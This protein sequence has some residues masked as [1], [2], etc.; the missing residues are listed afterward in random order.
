MDLATVVLTSALFHEQP[1][2]GRW[3]VPLMASLLVVGAVVVVVSRRRGTGM[4]RSGLRY[5]P[6]MVVVIIWAAIATPKLW[7]VWACLAVPQGLDAVLSLLLT[8][9]TRT[10]T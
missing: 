9:N 1:P 5:W 6:W 2:I 7:V 10:A 3:T 4:A 8:L